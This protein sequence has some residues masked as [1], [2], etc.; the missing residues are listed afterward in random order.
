[1]TDTTPTVPTRTRRSRRPTATACVT[2]AAGLVAVVAACGTQTDDATPGTPGAPGAIS[3][4]PGDVTGTSASVTEP[5]DEELQ[6]SGIVLDDG[7]GPQFCTGAIME[8]YPPQCSGPTVEDWDWDAVESEQASGVRW[9]T[10]SYRLTGT[11]DGET[12]ALTR[13][14]D[15]EADGA[16]AT[17]TPPPGEENDAFPALCT[18]PYRGGDESADLTLEERDA[19]TQEVRSRPGFVG[20]YVSDGDSDHLNVVVQADVDVEALHTSMRE[21][22][23]GFLCIE[24]RDAASEGDVLDAQEAVDAA[25]LD[26]VATDGDLGVLHVAVV[27]MDEST[28]AA[29]HEAASPWLTPEQV[30][31]TS[32][33]TPVT[34]ESDE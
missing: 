16:A 18:D 12:F 33:F 1:M 22:W 5:E 14:V 19:A 25:G 29:V 13:P 20:L 34:L 8:S 2:A 15:A 21:V 26:L 24:A 3:D 30:E 11:L 23:P 10:S 6:A 9:T 7:N 32:T 17:S 27:V 28:V 4:G 31:V